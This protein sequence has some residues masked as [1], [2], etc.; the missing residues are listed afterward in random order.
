[1]HILNTKIIFA[2]FP[3]IPSTSDGEWADISMQVPVRSCILSFTE[4]KFCEFSARLKGKKQ[5]GEY[6]L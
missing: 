5:D 4:K 1:M 6:V 2:D 3:C